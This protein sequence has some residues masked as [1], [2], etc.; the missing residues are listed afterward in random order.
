MEAAIHEVGGEVHAAGPLYR[1][2]TNE[3]YVVGA[4]HVD[5]F[6]DQETI[7]ADF[8]GVAHGPDGVDFHGGAAAYA[9]IVAARQRRRGLRI[10]R[11]D[12]QERLEDRGIEPEVGRELPQDGAELGAQ[13]QEA[14]G[15]EI[16]ERHADISQALHVGD[17]PGALYGENEIIGGFGRP[18]C[19]VPGALQR[20]K[21]AVDLDGGENAGGVGE[22]ALMCELCWIK[23][24]APGCVP[25]AGDSDAHF[26]WSGGCHIFFSPRLRL[27]CPADR[28]RKAHRQLNASRRCG[29]ADREIGVPRGRIAAKGAGRSACATKCSHMGLRRFEAADFGGIEFP[30]SSA[31]FIAAPL[32]V[33]CTL[34]RTRR[35]L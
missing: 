27:V 8:D 2:C 17:E 34:Y 7:V 35:G 29:I 22:L 28:S 31:S 20:V 25:P 14:R 3:R 1:V 19:E 11:E 13:A 15:Q 33:A 5:E 23:D 18:S 10:A 24:A 16:R 6:R 26:S 4:E 30:P 21:G 12:F 32:S 9:L